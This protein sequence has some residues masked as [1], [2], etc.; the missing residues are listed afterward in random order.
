MCCDCSVFIRSVLLVLLWHG[1]GRQSSFSVSAT[2]TDGL[3]IPPGRV[4]CESSRFF[5]SPFFVQ[6]ISVAL[7]K[8]LS[9]TSNITPWH[10]LLGVDPLKS[11][12]TCRCVRGAGTTC[13]SRFLSLRYATPPNS[14]ALLRFVIKATPRGGGLGG[15]VV[16]LVSVSIC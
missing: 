2:S 15:R 16:R 7:S 3:P 1:R 13:F 11:P 5:V 14:N 9:I 6:M 8:Y 4:A 12:P 10:R